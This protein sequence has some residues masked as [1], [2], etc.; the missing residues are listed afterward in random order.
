M[1][2]DDLKTRLRLPVVCAPMFLVSG[3]ELLIAASQAGILGSL[4]ASNARS[5]E[6]LMAWLVQIDAALTAGDERRPYAI[7]LIVR[8]ADS[9]RFADDLALIER[10]RPPVVITSVGKPGAVVERVHAYGGLVFHDVASMRHAERAMEAGVDGLILLTAGAGGH[11]GTANP[12]AFVPQVRRMFNGA[13][14][15]AGAIA[16]GRGVRA[17]EM[18]GA[19][20]AYV[21][22][23]F[24]AS[25]ESR[26]PREY[27]QMLIEQQMSDV[28][29]TDRISGMSATF[30]RASIARAGLDPDDLP[31]RT[32]LLQPAIPG[33]I[34]A[35]RDVWSGGHGTGLIDDVADVA[36]IVRRMAEDYAAAGA[37][38][39]NQGTTS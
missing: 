35:W 31:P 8:G 28:I 10:F 21:G 2:I 38:V 39:S 12:F 34:K 17:A 1:T 36:E 4:P 20:F 7:N 9:Q 24:A 18:L 3:P 37:G 25:T 26:A 16:D 13:I 29:T 22:T 6:E 5:S 32:G 14:L 11:T 30:L 19:D 33:T 27:K 23:R 15:L